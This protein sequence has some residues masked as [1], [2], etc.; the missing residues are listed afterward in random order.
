MYVILELMKGGPILYLDGKTFEY[1]HSLKDTAA[2]DTNV[3]M[4]K[5]LIFQVLRDVG[6]A[7]EYCMLRTLYYEFFST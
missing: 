4:D 5:K 1:K 2:K 6:S 7:L 3:L